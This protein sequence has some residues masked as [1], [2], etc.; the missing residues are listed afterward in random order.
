MY[1]VP[2]W[3]FCFRRLAVS[4]VAAAAPSACV[5]GERQGDA[6]EWVTRTSATVADQDERDISSLLDASSGARSPTAAQV[7]IRS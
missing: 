7:C 2:P 1:P 4:P 6:P 3:V 5:A